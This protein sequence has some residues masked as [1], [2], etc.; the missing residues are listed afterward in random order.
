MNGIPLP[1]SQSQVIN[2]R[3]AANEPLISIIA[4]GMY[5][6]LRRLPKYNDADKVLEDALHDFR[7]RDFSEADEYVK[8]LAYLVDFW[9]EKA[10]Q[11]LEF[12][13]KE[14][15]KMDEEGNLESL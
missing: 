1:K 6:T 11:Y 15:F 12:V 5:G 7:N 2:E 4:D 14:K 3:V 8:S 10:E 9:K 13:D